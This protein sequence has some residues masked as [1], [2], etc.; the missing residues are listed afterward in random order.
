MA[1]RIHRGDAKPVAQVVTISPGVVEIGRVYGL[2]INNK[3]VTVTAGSTSAATLVTA[4]ATALAAT[5]QAEFRELTVSGSGSVLT[6]TSRNAGVPF[7]VKPLVDGFTQGSALVITISNSPS[8]GTWLFTS[9]ETETYPGSATPAYNASAATVQTA[10]DGIYGAG[11]TL[12]SLVITDDGREYTIEMIGSLANEPVPAASV[13]YASLTGGNAAVE[14][15][16]TQ[17]AVAGTDCVQTTTHYGSATGGTRTFTFN[18]FTTAPLAYNASTGTVQTAMRALLSING[19]NVTVSGSAGSSYVFTFS[20]ELASRELPLITVDESGITG[21]SIFA[22]LTITE[23]AAGTNEVY[24]IE[25]EP[26]DV[27]A[28]V[29]RSEIEVSKTTFSGW[30]AGSWSLDS[31]HSG[32]DAVVIPFDATD[33]EIADLISAELEIDGSVIVTSTSTRIYIRFYGTASQY[34]LGTVSVISAITGGSVALVSDVDGSNPSTANTNDVSFQFA[35][36]SET[37][38]AL[39]ANA[40]DAAWQAAIEAMSFCGSGNVTVTT[41]NTGAATFVRAIEFKAGLGGQFV[42]LTLTGGTDS[43]GR[44]NIEEFRRGAA[45][46]ANETVEITINGS[47][48]QGSFILS[49][50]GNET[51]PIVYN[52]LASGVVAKVAAMSHVGTGNISGTGGPLPG[53]PV[54]LTFTGNLSQTDVPVMTVDDNA[55]K[56]SVEMTTPGVDGQNEIQKLDLSG[57]DV[58]AGTVTLT[59]DSIALDPLDYDMTYLDLQAEIDS[60]LGAN[61]ATVSGGPWPENPLY[62]EFDGDNEETDM[63]AITATDTLKNG[64]ATLASLDAM[65][66]DYVTSATGPNHWSNPINWANP[67]DPE[68]ATLPQSGDTVIFAD[69]KIDCLYGLVQRVAFTV[70]PSD[71]YVLPTGAHDLQNDQGVHVWTSDADLPAGLA[72]STMYYVKDLDVATGKFRLSTSIGGATVDITDAGTGTHQIGLRLEKLVHYSRCTTKIGLPR[73][74]AAGYWEYRPTYLAVGLL[75]GGSKTITIG[76]GDGQ[77]SSRVHIDTGTDQVLFE[78]L[79][80]S[81]GT[82]T[83]IPAVCALGNHASNAYKLRG[84]QLG[85]AVQVGESAVLSSIEQTGGELA[86]GIINLATFD[87]TGGTIIY[88]NGMTAS[89]LVMWR[90]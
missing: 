23:G 78:C 87:K 25:R 24:Y 44:L 1:T 18:G 72:V 79:N 43:V 85:I 70:S 22:S 36:L 73:L 66:I 62:V 35:T 67:T 69:T 42:Y 71:D 80:S 75:P 15:T 14:I 64:L 26:T 9:L 89:G 54:V 55:L 11:N 47:P 41:L 21:G 27:Y 37:S 10:M 68:D 19:A 45:T 39:A 2:R 90:S 38:A 6:L 31:T 88:L 16:T 52:E 81:S 49:Q 77:G 60:E 48:S 65:L 32:F 82:V 46:G 58:W 84:G 4:L 7:S 3:D 59:I 20:G 63:P 40:T 74:N 17:T 86:M 5:N 29:A 83:Q 51:D 13:S 12:V 34:T 57:Q 76:Q 53:T 30:S 8:G 61:K 33:S 56:V 28:P 50:S